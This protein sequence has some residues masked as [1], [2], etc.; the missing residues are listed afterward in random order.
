[1]TKRKLL[2]AGRQR[3][4]L[5]VEVM[6]PA[7]DLEG[8]DYS[9]RPPMDYTGSCPAR[10]ELDRANW[11][12]CLVAEREHFTREAEVHEKERMEREAMKE[13]GLL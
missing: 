6:Q 3:T 11:R 12:R 9:A 4:P 2:V 5:K 10:S 8:V 7:P 1:M 13:R